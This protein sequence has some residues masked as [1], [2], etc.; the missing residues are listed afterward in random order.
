MQGKSEGLLER[1]LGAV[2]RGDTPPALCLE[3]PGEAAQG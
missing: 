1:S 2:P 3:S